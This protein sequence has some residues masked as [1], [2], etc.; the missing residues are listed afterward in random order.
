[1]FKAGLIPPQVGVTTLNTAI[2]WTEYNMRPNTKVEPFTASSPSG[3]SLVSI[4]AS[5]LGGANGHCVVES[6][7][8]P[9]RSAPEPL[10][11]DMPILLIAGGLS[12]RTA[13]AI[14][15]DVTQLATEIPPRAFRAFDSEWETFEADDLAY[16]CCQQC[17]PSVCLPATSLRSADYATHRFRVRRSRATTYRKYEIQVIICSISI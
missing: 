1:M 7:P 2:G 16:S 10:P 14:A 9:P 3:A 15:S 17:R 11:A 6:F 13:T 5:G 8:Y 12:P 4:N